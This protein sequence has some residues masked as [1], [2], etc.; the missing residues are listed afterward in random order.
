MGRIGRKL[1]GCL[2][3]LAMGCQGEV[4][5]EGAELSLASLQRELASPREESC[6]DIQQA[7][8]SAPDGEYTLYVLGDPAWPWRVYCHGMTGVPKE[9]LPLQERTLFSNFSQYTAGVASPGT[10]VRSRYS[11]LRINPYTLEVDTSDTTFATST[12]ELAHAGLPVTSMPF[13]TAMS[14][15]WADSGRANIDLR[16]TP[17]RVAPEAFAVTGWGQVGSQVYSFADQVVSLKGGGYCGSN[18]PLNADGLTGGKLPLFYTLADSPWTPVAR[19]YPVDGSEATAK[20]LQPGYYLTQDL[21]LGPQGLGAVH[22]PRGWSVVLHAGPGFTGT[23]HFLGGDAE[24]V[25]NPWYRQARGIEVKAEVT[26]HAGHGYQGARQT[27]RAGRYDLSQLTIGNDALRSIEVP[28]GFQ[29]T[30][31]WHGGFQGGRLILTENT[32]LAGHEFDAQTSSIIVESTTARHNNIV[33]G[34]WLSSGGQDKGSTRNRAFTVDYTGRPDVV[35]FELEAGVD[36]YLYLLDANG[37]VLLE[38]GETLGDG[39]ARLAYFLSP[40]TYK[41]VAATAQAGRTADFTVR[42]DKARLSYPQKLWVRTVNT[43]TWAYDDSGTGSHDDVSV[44]RPDLS[45]HPGYYSL[46]DIAMPGHGQAPRMTFAVSGE[47]DLLARPLYYNRI[48]ED[49]GTGGNH[50]AAFWQPVP[51]PGYTCLG[52]V[53][54]LGY[55]APPTDRIRCVK[56]EY[57][58]PAGASWV[59]NDKGSGKASGDIALWQADP[60]DHRTLATSTFVG[61]GNYDG[62]DGS[63]FWAL[64][65]SALA[66]PELQGGFVDDLTVLRYAP[67]IR[68]HPNETYFPAGMNDF[69]PNMVDDGTRLRTRDALACPECTNLPFLQGKRPDQHSVPVY[70]QIIPR[71]QA[72]LPTNTTDVVYWLFYPYNRGKPICTQWHHLLRTCMQYT[73]F[74]NHVGDWEHLTLRFVDGRPTQLA[75]SQ[76]AGRPPTHFASKDLALVDLHPEVYAAQGSHGLYPAPGRYTYAQANFSEYYHDDTGPGLAWDGWSN[77]VIFPWQPAGT[78]TT[79]GLERFNLTVDWG[80]DKAGCGNPNLIYV[81]DCILNPGPK[82][83]MARPFTQPGNLSMQ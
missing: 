68:L 32:D 59:W 80:N 7:R 30:L 25:G 33:H 29:V 41:L 19:V 66:N 83:P 64:N 65:N 31:Y 49:G 13:A 38:G 21:N 45:Q 75:M 26:L 9:Y 76:R 20:P 4:L 47:G 34:R 58:L 12:G 40:G 27:L 39:R 74:D 72:G 52:S 48:W 23:R 24:I 44:W 8:P 14:C 71:T 11:R 70:A 15:D 18:A 78:Y 62:P 43:F 3:T 61:Q 1:L 73:T 63:R 36:P 56:D 60:R 82:A 81:S 54:E 51:P 67:R 46:G 79:P 55:N 22:V 53:V 35:S 6:L 16:G 69:V 5:E 42:S 50:D 77:A 17:F 10:T 57:V 37:Q 28:E 2:T